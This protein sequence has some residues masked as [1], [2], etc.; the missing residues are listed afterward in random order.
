MNGF[1]PNLVAVLAAAA[2][3]FAIGAVWY[4]PLL[5]GDIWMAEAGLSAAPRRAGD[6]AKT[7]A[8]AVVA[9]LVMSYGLEM[10]IGPT[11]EVA[12]GFYSPSQQGAFHGFLTGAVW[13]V[14]AL[15]GLGLFERRSWTYI[16]LNGGYWIV[17]MTVMG[18]ILGA[19]N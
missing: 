14:P 8:I 17:A 7:C 12:D 6:T 19:W 16:A 18:G 13:I 3:A 5:L 11:H 15:V 4:S 1:E 2:A 9:L 10:S